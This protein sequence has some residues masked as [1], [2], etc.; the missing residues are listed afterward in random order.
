[1]LESQ[2]GDPS[3]P[4]SSCLVAASAAK[5]SAHCVQIHRRP[6]VSHRS[7]P[8]HAHPPQR[9]QGAA[10]AASLHR[11]GSAVHHCGAA[12]MMGLQ[13]RR[14]RPREQSRGVPSPNAA[15][16]AALSCRWLRG[17]VDERM[18]ACGGRGG[19]K[20]AG[21]TDG[22]PRRA[23][24]SPALVLGRGSGAGAAMRIRCTPRS[25]TTSK[26]ERPAGGR[27]TRTPHAAREDSSAGRSCRAD[28]PGAGAKV[29]FWSCPR[30]VLPMA[31]RLREL[32]WP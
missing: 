25:A 30:A 23:P 1:M 28:D 7:A 5:I 15:R 14:R 20:V 24:A 22:W 10:T 6:V 3:L 31:Q 2:P 13:G 9:S 18:L 29:R 26:S 8:S 17:R 11:G 4:S 19:R 27:R 12:A 16:P 21:M 32:F